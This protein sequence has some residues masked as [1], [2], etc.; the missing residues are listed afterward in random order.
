MKSQ[1]I[2]LFYTSR[3]FKM[4]PFHR[5]Y[6]QSLTKEC[7]PHKL[8]NVWFSFRKPLWPLT[9]AG[10]NKIWNLDDQNQTTSLSLAGQQTWTLLK[11]YK[12]P[13][14]L[15]RKRKVC[16][17]L[18]CPE[19]K[20]LTPDWNH[21]WDASSQT[22]NTAMNWMLCPF[23]F[24]SGTNRGGLKVL[25]HCDTLLLL[26]FDGILKSLELQRMMPGLVRLAFLVHVGNKGRPFPQKTYCKW[27]AGL[28]VWCVLARV[29]EAQWGTM[30]AGVSLNLCLHRIQPQ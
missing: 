30:L 24:H 1:Q 19:R 23:P 7:Q 28:Q 10:R 8:E 25:T 2:Q 13:R 27:A 12:P 20:M 29:Q 26:N 18:K 4:I 3:H 15:S 6:L 14:R 11:E 22:V 16:I 5:H 9:R 17:M 21:S